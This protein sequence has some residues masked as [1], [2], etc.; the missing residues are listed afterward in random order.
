M[1]RSFGI[2]T[3]PPSNRWSEIIRGPSKADVLAHVEK[4]ARFAKTRR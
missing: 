1:L 3:K 4:L 2:D